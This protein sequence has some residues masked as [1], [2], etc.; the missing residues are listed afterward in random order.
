M[1]KLQ[2]FYSLPKVQWGIGL[3]IILF[4]TISYILL[5][6]NKYWQFE[7][8]SVDNVYFDTA[9]WKLAHFKNPIV[10]HAVMGRIS[11]FGDHFH[12]VIL[13]FAALYW[14]TD[15]QE[16]ILIAMSVV[17]GLSAILAMQISFKLIKSR[18]IT[19]VLLIAYFMYLGTQHAFLAGF[20]ELNFMP[21]FF[22][23]LMFSIINNHWRFYWVALFLFL[24]VNES[25][26]FITITLSF[27]IFFALK[28]RKK[29]AIITVLISCVYY[30]VIS[31]Y[32]IPAFSHRF[33]YSQIDLPNDI[34][35]WLHHFVYPP[36]KKE[37]FIVSLSTFAFLPLLNP[38]TLP[39]V[40]QD[41]F[42]RYIFEI[43]GNVQYTLYYHYNLALVPLL[44]FST[45]WTI[46]QF[47]EMKKLKKYVKFLPLLGVIILLST[48]YFHR[49]Y[50]QRGP[51]LLV[52]NPAFYQTTKDNAFEWEFVKKI[53]RDGTIMTQNHLAYIFAH[54]GAYLMPDKYHYFDEYHVEHF[55]PVKQEYIAVDLRE[56]QNPNNY[57]PLGEGGT[58]EMIQDLVAKKQYKIIY[59]KDAEYILKKVN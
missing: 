34:P 14:F 26:I 27:F 35:D 29:E 33:L 16:V 19:Y 22:F 55:T 58:K 39:L 23:L 2:K 28:N 3:S 52:T 50:K 17:F 48:I 54:Q 20:H 36:E 21:F 59:H 57:F 49:L 43:S 38:F 13:L 46:K 44:Y 5:L 30:Y 1:K 24:F 53:P 15:K 11:I 32:V 42:V 6:L 31:H 41:F 4:F 8:F 56:G 9:L 25:M 47:Q 45:V 51:L 18:F 40:L 37:T 12:P 7:F 10:D